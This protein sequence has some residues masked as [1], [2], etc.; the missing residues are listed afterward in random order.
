MPHPP[1]IIL[2]EASG[3]PIYRQIYET[4]R[5][6][7]LQREFFPGKLL[8][9]SRFL[10][11]QLGISRMTVINAYDQLTAE[12]YLESKKGAGTFVAEHLPEEFFQTPRIEIQN[13]KTET[14]GRNHKFSLYGKTVFNE[15]KTVLRFNSPTPVIPFQHGLAAINDFPF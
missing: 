12:G 3:I 1:F 8:P 11:K 15:I 14:E 4:I 6:A 5:R 13:K 10:A 2:D 7:I 9:P